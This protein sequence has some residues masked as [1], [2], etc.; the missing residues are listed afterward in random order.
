MSPPIEHRCRG[1]GTL[2]ASSR[3]TRPAI[4]PPFAPCPRCGGFVARPPFQE[5]VLLG[6]LGRM[7]CL[8]LPAGIALVT[9]LIP[10]LGYAGVGLALPHGRDPV[11]LLIVAGVGLCVSVAIWLASLS[12]DVRRSQRRMADPMYRAKL[13]EFELATQ[14]ARRS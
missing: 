12:R 2:V 4:G 7:R 11:W 8:G 5:W 9:G 1:C 3:R 14:G 13:V 10:A 6:A